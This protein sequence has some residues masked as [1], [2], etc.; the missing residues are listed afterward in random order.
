MI[1]LFTTP[2]NFKGEFNI[3]Q[4]NALNSWRSISPD[5]QIIIIGNSEGNEEA[6]DSIKAEFISNVKCSKEGTP[7]LSDLFAIA[8]SKAKNEIMA[9]INADIILPFDFLESI[10]IVSKHFHKFLLIGQRWDLDVDKKIAFK[11]EKA[12]KN[13]W[14][15]A[16]TKSKKHGVS[17]IDYFV[18]RKGMYKNLPDFVVGRWAWDNWL[19]WKARRNMLPVIDG[20]EVIRVIHQNHSYKF[21]N[22][23]SIQDSKSGD[24]FKNN[25]KLSRNKLLN[26]LDSTHIIFGGK[27]FRKN[28]KDEKIRYLHRLPNIFPEISI[29]IKIYRRFYKRIN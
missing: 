21:H 2:K 15:S 17:G 5:I 10:E 27:I 20:T 4:T 13:F 18:F 22:I 24:E 16:Y 1:T 14:K 25:V 11:D 29:L 12:I 26:I 6:A 23:R 8:Q 9:Y 28:K 7:L 19:I 3:I